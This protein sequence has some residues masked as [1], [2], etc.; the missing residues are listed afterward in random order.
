[1]QREKAARVAAEQ[2]EEARAAHQSR[3]GSAGQLCESSKANHLA[4]MG[5]LALENPE[6]YTTEPSHP[7]YDVTAAVAANT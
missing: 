4:V 5:A 3:K 1:M 7:N 6:K 2:Q